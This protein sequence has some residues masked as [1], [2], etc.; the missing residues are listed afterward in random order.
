MQK[1]KNVTL[2]ASATRT[3]TATGDAV[4]TAGTIKPITGD[5][6]GYT[7]AMSVYQNVGTVSG[8][9][10]TLDLDIQGSA[11]GTNWFE[12]TALAGTAA[13]DWTQVTASTNKQERRYM[14][15]LPNYVRA[16]ATIGGTTPSYGTHFVT[17]ILGGG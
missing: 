14:G 15:P 7:Y 10:P 2:L 13:S 5:Q 6:E 9:N 1:T 16:V 3:A 8:T 17:A 4:S 11:D 12:L